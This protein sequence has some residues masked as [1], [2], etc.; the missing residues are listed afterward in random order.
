MLKEAAVFIVY[1]KS[2]KLALS[3]KRINPQKSYFGQNIFP[4]GEIEGVEIEE[5][6]LTV[7]RES[8]E[9]LGIQNIQLV[10]IFSSEPLIG[11]MGEHIHL[12]LI[13]EWDGQIPENAIDSHYPLEWISLW[14][15][16]ESDLKSRM[17]MSRLALDYL[18]QEGI[19]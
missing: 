13:L 3:E 18:Y 1:D 10:Q 17:I 14:D 15:S 16:A 6:S 5:P 12:F 11:E 8:K 2:Q 9:E 4:G 19:A 7:E